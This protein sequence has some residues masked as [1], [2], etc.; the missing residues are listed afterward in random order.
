MSHDASRA[1]F[2]PLEYRDPTPVPWLISALGVVN[3]HLILGGLLRFRG[4]VLP[5]ADRARLR[6]AVNPDTVAFLGPAH[7]EFLTDWMIDKEISC[8]CS[9]LM[10][11]WASYEIVNLSP[12]VRSFWL[13]N[14]LIA[15]VPGGGGKAYSVRWAIAGHGVL[16]HPE[17][18]ATWQGERIATLLPGLADMAWEAATTLAAQGSSRPV[19]MVPLVWRLVFTRNAHGP[20]ARDLADLARRVGVAVPIGDLAARFAAL[21]P[22]LLAHQC[23]RLGLAAPTA[24]ERHDYFPA[25]AAVLQQ[26]RAMLAERYGALDEDL[27]RAQF[28]LR[29]AMR[30][31]MTHDPDGVRAD[32]ARL[33]ELQRLANFDPALYDRERLDQERIAEVLKRMRATLLT[34]QPGDVLRNTLPI[35][36]APRRVHVRVAEPI[37]VH[38]VRAA[39]APGDETQ[40]RAALLATHHERLQRT[41]DALGNE[42]AGETRRHAVPNALW[43]GGTTH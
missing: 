43:S 19:H 1:R 20:L 40:A 18:T 34:A 5:E 13:A 25:Q 30:E 9:P 33:F 39:C 36:V 38:A 3:R 16:L 23:R 15:N 4:L 17:G 11:H 26:L 24:R 10:A 7:P 22:A 35:A 8:L 31:R 12:A 32:R 6:A 29:K 37:A 42:L 2:T 21:M 14:N 28:Q 41:L 27:T